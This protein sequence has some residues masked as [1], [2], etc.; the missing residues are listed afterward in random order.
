MQDSAKI[1]IDNNQYKSLFIHVL[2]GLKS[3]IKLG[4]VG[5]FIVSFAQLNQA[6]ISKVD[7]ANIKLSRNYS[8]LPWNQFVQKIEQNYSVHFYYLSG[9]FPDFRISFDSESIVLKKVLSDHFLQYNVFVTYDERGHIF[10]SKNSSITTQLSPRFFKAPAAEEET[11]SV[12]STS[13]NFIQTTKEF[14]AKTIIVGTKEGGVNK[15]TAMLSGIAVNGM[16]GKNVEGATVVDLISGKGTVTDEKGFYKLSL[17]KGKHVLKISSV[18]IL[19]KQIEIDLRSTGTL[20]ILLDDKIIMLQDV[21]VSAERDNKVLGTQMGLDK[22]STKNVK[23]IPLVF[24]EKDIV[25][26]A[27]L[28]PGVQSVGEG[29]S[30]F[31]VRGSPTDQNVFYINNLPIYNTSHVAGFFSAFNA[32]VVE[33]F[34]LYKSN[35]PLQYGGRLS[36]VFEIKT[37]A[38]NKDHFTAR[39]GIGPITGR[40]TVEGPIKKEKSSFLIGMR[41]TYSDWILNFVKDPIIKNSHAKFGDIVTNF[42]FQPTENNQFNFFTYYSTDQME[43]F[44]QSNYDYQNFGLSANWKHFFNNQK[45]SLEVSLAHSGYKFSE[46]NTQLEVAAYSHNNQLGHTEFKAIYAFAPIENHKFQVGINSTLYAIDKGVYNPLTGISLINYTDLGKEKGLESAFFISDEWK[47]NDKLTASGG[48]RFNLFTYLGEQDVNIY[49]EGLPY[50]EDN[51]LEVVHYSNWEPIKTYGGLD[52]RIGMNYLIKDNVSVKVAYNR[53][54]QYIY[55]LSNTIAVSPNY[56]WKLSDYNTEP[57]IGDQFTLGF[58]S[59]IWNN[60]YEFSIETYYKITQNVVEIKDG[61]NLFF[62]QNTEQATLQ[63][64]LDA[65][66]IELML[67]KNVGSLTGWINYT[68]S[69]SKVLVDSPFAEN[70]INYGE[71]YPSNYDKPHAFNL[72]ANYDL[73]RRYAISGNIVYSTGRPITYPTSIYYLNDIPTLSYSSRNAYRIPDYLRLDLSLNV[74]GNL[75]KRKLGHGTWA[76]SVYNVLGRKNAFSVYYEETDGN[77]KAYKLSIFGAPIFSVSYNFKLGNYASE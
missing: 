61:A 4:L 7:I 33:E 34:S 44:T 2:S 67:K 48:L 58:Y 38:G 37:K 65:Y 46:E 47:I 55:M 3:K 29:S 31:N 6:Q 13:T 26:V 39:G 40:V 30:G 57:I 56:K 1:S 66:G 12:D 64:N 27:L 69:N 74:E 21:I 54:H 18:N 45:N 43:L 20:D 14:I 36:S 51:I 77:I 71:P 8:D 52:Y 28:L 5:L 75:L 50:T 59:N 25:K 24:G 16:T 70:R 62:N 53:L 11:E 10:L 19:E 15:R 72:V 32:D 23:K 73:S 17:N 42:N 68:Y 60:R 22:V 76:F 63:G 41:S 35:I 49:K 9:D